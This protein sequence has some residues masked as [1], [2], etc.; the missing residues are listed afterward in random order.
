MK[1]DLANESGTV[2]VSLV[3]GEETDYTAQVY[4]IGDCVKNVTPYTT[5]DGCSVAVTNIKRAE[6]LG[7]VVM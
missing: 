3:Y 2:Y 4:G 6:S 7:D 5:P 1:V